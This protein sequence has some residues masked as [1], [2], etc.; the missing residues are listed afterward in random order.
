MRNMNNLK[1]LYCLSLISTLG[2]LAPL[3]SALG[4]CGIT[5]EAAQHFGIS[6]N[7]IYENNKTGAPAAC[8]DQANVPVLPSTEEIYVRDN[9][10][11]P[12]GTLLTSILIMN[13]ERLLNGYIG[14]ILRCNYGTAR[15]VNFYYDV[16]SPEPEISM[17]KYYVTAPAGM[18]AD[19]GVS[20]RAQ[21]QDFPGTLTTEN[22]HNFGPSGTGLGTFDASSIPVVWARFYRLLNSTG[23]KQTTFTDYPYIQMVVRY[24]SMHNNPL[25]KPSY[26]RLNLQIFPNS[27]V[28][29][30]ATCGVSLSNPNVTLGTVSRKDIINGDTPVV[31][32]QFNYICDGTP[33]SPVQVGLQPTATSTIYKS[34]ILSPSSAVTSPARFVGVSFSDKPGADFTP[35]PLLPSTVCTTVTSDGYCS[36]S[37]DIGNTI[38]T[39][40]WLPV[41]EKHLSGEAHTLYA[42][43]VQVGVSTPYTGKFKVDANIIVAHY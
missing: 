29:Q 10:F 27:K 5:T 20:I 2:A 39:V 24:Y 32:F 23:T 16:I 42:K 36:T 37:P 25:S 9:V 11:Q 12:P 3:S 15:T 43:M 35:L 6:S 41:T 19:L 8:D 7:C 26:L 14:A 18:P 40:G 28:D 30:R 31:P 4:F 1:K 22:I 13:Y 17:S 33:N 38:G 21:N 34:T